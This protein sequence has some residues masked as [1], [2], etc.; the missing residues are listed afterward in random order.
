MLDGASVF[1]ALCNVR[2]SELN[3]TDRQQTKGA[4]RQYD[5][6]SGGCCDD[7]SE[8]WQVMVWYNED[9]MAARA[10]IES[11]NWDED[12]EAKKKANEN[13]NQK[14]KASKEAKPK[15]KATVLRAEAPEFVPGS[16][17]PW[18]LGPGADE[19]EKGM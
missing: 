19:K 10:R 3:S 13:T 2:L 16:S 17:L 15:K 8:V 4:M 12:D 11:G 7:C 5:L 14:E 1:C 9:E 6:M 18:A